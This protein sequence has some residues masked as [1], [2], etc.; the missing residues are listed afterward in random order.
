M[1]NSIRRHGDSEGSS[2]TA[3]VISGLLPHP[4]IVVPA[5]GGSRVDGCRATHDACREL[6]R[7]VVSRSP[8]RLILPSP[9]SPRRHTAFGLSS[10][11]RIA[12]DL[13][14]FGAP[15]AGIDL[16]ADPEMAKRI[17]REAARRGLQTW[18]LPA[19]EPLDHG[20]CVPLWFLC[21][22]GWRGPTTLVSLPVL[23]DAAVYERFGGVCA[24]AAQELDGRAAFVASGDMSHRVL[25]GAPAGFHH[26]AVEFDHELTELVR[27]GRLREIAT[28]DHELREL[29]AEDAADT[30]IMA[31]AAAEYR[32]DG[33]QVLSYEHPFGVGYLV[34]IFFDELAAP[35]TRD[36]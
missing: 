6:A 32:S 4:P 33:H 34:A 7:R 9:H 12:G 24:R 5:V 13:R 17:R 25:P 30:S 22:A 11:A 8:G 29:A 35:T 18:D 20:A 27:D 2:S 3:F 26:R 16:P 10:A 21:E 31:C 14:R 36:Q 1:E 15:D 28:I 23:R 19:D